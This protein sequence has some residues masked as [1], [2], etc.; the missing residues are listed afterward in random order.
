M[1]SVWK[2]SSRR[3]NVMAR[4]A[5]AMPYTGTIASGLRP[6]GAKWSTK[7][8][9][10]AGL[11]GSAPAPRRRRRDRSIF[12]SFSGDVRF[13]ARPYAKFGAKVMVPLCF[14]MTS[15]QTDGRLM[16]LMVG[17]K[18]VSRPTRRGEI[19]KPMRPMS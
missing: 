2:G 1:T 17:M 18:T 3:E 13:T 12:A 9:R 4:V 7:A 5:S 14:E 10:V 11:F 19:T 16:K 8:W 6:A 15:I